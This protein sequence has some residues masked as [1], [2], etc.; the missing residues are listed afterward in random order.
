MVL[1]VLETAERSCCFRE[2][3]SHLKYPRLFSMR[4]QI[5]LSARVV[6]DRRIERAMRARNTKLHTLH[7]RPMD[8]F[9]LSA[10]RLLCWKM[11]DVKSKCCQRGYGAAFH[12][13][14]CHRYLPYLPT[15]PL[16]QPSK[17]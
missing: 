1:A 9:W 15:L 17:H 12:F 8:V 11:A 14:Q 7:A 13:E 10:S 2:Q 16:T 5:R 4:N 6:K 3:A